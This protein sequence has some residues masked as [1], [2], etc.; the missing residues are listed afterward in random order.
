VLKVAEVAFQMMISDPPL[1]FD[2]SSTGQKVR[3][4]Q[5]KYESLDG[6]AKQDEECFIILPSVH[7]Q[8]H[9]QTVGGG[10]LGEVLVK[11]FVLPL[12]YEF[13]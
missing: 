2:L 9:P 4:N 12:S 3:F 11:A 5:Y 7:K 13:P 1:C 10:T 6:F 8:V